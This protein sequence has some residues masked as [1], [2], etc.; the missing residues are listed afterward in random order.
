MVLFRFNIFLKK[1]KPL[2]TVHHYNYPFYLT[3]NPLWTLVNSVNTLK[4]NKLAPKSQR[5]VFHSP[6]LLR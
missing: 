4:R 3:L 5:Y 6:N 1:R 2:I